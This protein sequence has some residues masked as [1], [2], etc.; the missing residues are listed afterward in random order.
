[1]INFQNPDVHF[2]VIR[3]ERLLVVVNTWVR[4]VEVRTLVTIIILYLS[5]FANDGT[6]FPVTRSIPQDTILRANF[7]VESWNTTKLFFDR[8]W[9]SSRYFLPLSNRSGRKVVIYARVSLLNLRLTV[10]GIE[11]AFTHIY[12]VALY[13]IIRWDNKQTIFFHVV[14][15]SVRSHLPVWAFLNAVSRCRINITMLNY[16]RN[17][18]IF[19]V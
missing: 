19:T 9:C 3:M 12:W 16:F 2:L 10:L 11:I 1:M 17:G 5:R 14:Q 7:R 18:S 6:F 13:R 15:E 8:I 4:A